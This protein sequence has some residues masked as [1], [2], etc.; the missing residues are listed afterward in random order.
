MESGLTG[1]GWVFMIA[2]IGGVWALAIFCYK[3]LLFDD[4]D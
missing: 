4:D 1:L 2:S 3:K